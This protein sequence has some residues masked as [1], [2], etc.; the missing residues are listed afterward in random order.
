M[1]AQ[2][3]ASKPPMAAL[4]PTAAETQ[5]VTRSTPAEYPDCTVVTDRNGREWVYSEPTDTWKYIMPTDGMTA[6]HSA[7][8]WQKL[9]A[10]FGPVIL[11]CH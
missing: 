9:L 3:P 11:K 2:P 1:N 8:S 7:R 5:R 4:P 10:D 6:P